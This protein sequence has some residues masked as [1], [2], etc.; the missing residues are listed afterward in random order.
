MNIGQA[1]SATTLP[2]KTIRY[3]EEIGLVTPNR[4]ANGYRVFSDQHIHTLH[5]LAKARGLGFTVE[6]CRILLTLYSDHARASADV[7]MIAAKHV[8]AIEQKIKELQSMHATLTHLI[9]TCA[10]DGRPDCPILDELSGSD[11]A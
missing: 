4:S 8:A 7:K 11:T 9:N 6:D 3:Y 5:F 2:E 1:A 10:G